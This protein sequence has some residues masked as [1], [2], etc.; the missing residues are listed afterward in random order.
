MK[1]TTTAN[2]PVCECVMEFNWETTEI[3]HFGEAM[4]IA[5]FCQC[6]FRHSDTILLSQKEPARYTLEVRDLDD[7][8][9]RV[10]RSSSGTIR[11]P[12]LGVDIEPGSASESYISNVEGVLDR[13]KGV[14]I[15]ATN[16]ARGAGELDKASR[17]EQILEHIEMARQ[18]QF[19]LTFMIEDP[20]GNSA[21]AS[22]KAIKS[23]LTDEEIVNLKTGMILLDA[24]DVGS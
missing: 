2:C 12:E 7:L 19:K 24:C 20:L 8:D 15:F 4:I 14:V 16:S 9:A 6:G 10:I 18:G 1:L 21:I 22:E 3:P 11:V 23:S 13:I 17:G 5:G